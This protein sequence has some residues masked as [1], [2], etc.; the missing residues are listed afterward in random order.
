MSTNSSGQTFVKF[1]NPTTVEPG[2]TVGVH[3]KTTTG[4][5]LGMTNHIGYEYW[6][7][8]KR[9]GSSSFEVGTTELSDSDRNTPED[10]L[11]NR[12]PALELHIS[13][14]KIVKTFVSAIHVT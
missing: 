14:G 4:S 11:Y 7:V 12:I 6:L 5:T 3:T 1:S 10:G 8:H 2:L 9:E 13:P